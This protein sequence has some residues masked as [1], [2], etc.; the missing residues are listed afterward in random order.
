MSKNTYNY[1]LN[2]TCDFF[3][4]LNKWL[5]KNNKKI[6]SH[7]ETNPLGMVLNDFKYYLREFSSETDPIKALNEWLLK[8][9]NNYDI[10]KD[11]KE[12]SFEEWKP[13]L[14]EYNWCNK[15]DN[16]VKKV[17]K[18]LGITQKELAERLGVNDVTVRNWSSKDNAPEWATKFMNLLLDYEKVKTKANKASQIIKLLDELKEK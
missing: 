2:H 11:G 6:N 8:N 9:E 18:E 16:I 7:F 1:W 13:L 4:E 10:W 12:S 14:I 3:K 17:C 15:E 5:Q